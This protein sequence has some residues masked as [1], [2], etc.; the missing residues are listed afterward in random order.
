MDD[1]NQDSTLPFLD[2]L[3]SPGLDNTLTTT[4]YRKP[5]HM[6]QHFHLDG[7]H[8]ISAKNNVFN[9]FAHTARM[10]CTNQSALEQEIYHIRKT[11][12]A[13][14]FPPWPLNSLQL[15]FKHKHN[16]TNPHTAS[17]GQYINTNNTVSR[18]KNSSQEYHI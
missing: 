16:T 7:N 10:V 5:T 1:P 2:T 14:K 11:L 6:D 15:K 4:V 3:V 18:N 12:L 9:T 13:C 17:N 8:S